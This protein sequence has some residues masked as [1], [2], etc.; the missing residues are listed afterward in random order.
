MNKT[1]NFQMYVPVVTDNWFL[2]L[3]LVSPNF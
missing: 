2:K 1:I 3:G